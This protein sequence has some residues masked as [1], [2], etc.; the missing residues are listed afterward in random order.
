MVSKTLLFLY[1]FEKLSIRFLSH[2]TTQPDRNYI[3]RNYSKI[4]QIFC[5]T[6][7]RNYFLAR[8]VWVK[9]KLDFSIV[10]RCAMWYHLYNLK[11][12]ENTHGV[13]LLY[14]VVLHKFKHNFEDMLNP[15][16]P[17]SLEAEDTYH[18]FCVANNSLINKFYFLVLLTPLT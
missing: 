9:D 8:T 2:F 16:S 7:F 1:N 11:K 15:L 14:G 3:T 4:R 17:Y 13:V 5:I 10:M 12:R 18:F 6:V